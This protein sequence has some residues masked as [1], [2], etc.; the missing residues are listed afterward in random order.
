MTKFIGYQATM[1]QNLILLLYGVQS[2]NYDVSCAFFE[3]YKVF[4]I[5][6]NHFSV[7][8]VWLLKSYISRY[9]SLTRCHKRVLFVC[10]PK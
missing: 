3:K 8:T 6:T 7:T 4:L 2:V 10:E 1:L 9:V 5:N